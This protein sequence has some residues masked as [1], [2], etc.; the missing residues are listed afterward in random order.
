MKAVNELYGDKDTF[1]PIFQANIES[2]LG[3]DKEERIRAVEEKLAELQKELL[4]LA[5]ARKDYESV[6]VEIDALRDEKQAILMEDAACEG[7]KQQ[8]QDMMDYLNELPCEVTEYEEQ[9]VRRLVEKITVLDESIVV[10]FKS[11]VEIEVT[12]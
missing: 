4:E 7:A 11:G 8:V 10:A 6:A 9:L 1:F 2:A 5:N 12:G 3:K